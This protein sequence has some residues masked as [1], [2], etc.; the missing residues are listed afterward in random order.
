MAHK[1]KKKLF[2]FLEVWDPEWF[3][4]AVDLGLEHPHIDN[5]TFGRKSMLFIWF[6]NLE[7]RR[8]AEDAIEDAGWKVFPRYS[9]GGRKAEVQVSYFKG[10]RYWE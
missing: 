2:E 5:E 6:E 10:D 1:S 7:H 4:G 8:A 3:A 9:P